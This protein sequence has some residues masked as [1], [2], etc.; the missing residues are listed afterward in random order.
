MWRNDKFHGFHE[1]TCYYHGRNLVG[2]V[3]G[4]VPPTS[5]PWETNYVLSPLLF[6]LQLIIFDGPLFR[7]CITRETF[8][9]KWRDTMWKRGRFLSSHDL[10]GHAKKPKSF[11]TKI[12]KTQLQNF[13]THFASSGPKGCKSGFVTYWHHVVQQAKLQQVDKYCFWL[14]MFYNFEISS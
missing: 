3:E 2:D 4:H 14:V 8:G 9:K 10:T 11:L 13:K 6:H 12:F 1:C 7:C 5:Y